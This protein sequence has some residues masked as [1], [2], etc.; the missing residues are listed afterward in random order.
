MRKLRKHYILAT[1]G[2]RFNVGCCDSTSSGEPYGDRWQSMSAMRQPHDYRLLFQAL[3]LQLLSNCWYS[4]GTLWIYNTHVVFWKRF[5]VNVFRFIFL[6]S[7]ML[8]GAVLY[9]WCFSC[10]LRMYCVQLIFFP[11]ITFSSLYYLICIKIWWG[12]DPWLC[13]GWRSLCISTRVPLWFDN[14]VDYAVC[15]QSA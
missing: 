4:P 6:L 11:T 14:G 9:T 12:M 8:F 1:W 15:R 13:C 2:V 10:A 3:C 5:L 7:V